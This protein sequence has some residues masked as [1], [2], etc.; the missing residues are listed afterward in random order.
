MTKPQFLPP[1]TYVF[2]FYF[3]VA[4]FISGCAKDQDLFY[5]EVAEDILENNEDISIED[6][7]DNSDV[8][9]EDEK[10]VVIEPVNDAFIQDSK[11][12]NESI[13]RV[14]SDIRTA[15]MMFNLKELQTGISTVDLNITIVEDAGDGLI[16]VYKGS[17]NNWNEE[18]L[19]ESNAPKAVNLLGKSQG[20]YQAQDNVIIPLESG[21]FNEETISLVI[22][23]TN[24]NDI[25]FASKEI[26]DPTMKPNLIINS[27]QSGDLGDTTGSETN[28]GGTPKFDYNTTDDCDFGGDCMYVDASCMDSSYPSI[29]EFVTA[30]VQGGIPSNLE[31]KST[32]TPRDNI[33]TAIDQVYSQGGGTII[34]TPGTYSVTSTINMRSNV[35][36]RGTSEDEVIIESHLR[37]PSGWN[38]KKNTFLFEDTS[39]SGLE[40]LTILFKVDGLEPRD[41]PSLVD[42]GWCSDCYTNDPDGYD[43]LHVRQVYFSGSSTN[44][45]I[46]HSRILKSGNDPIS[47]SGD[48]NTIRNT[49][50][51]QAYNK[52]GGGNGY[53]LITGDH[54]L[55][56]NNTV[57][58]IR[59]I[60]I[61]RGAEYNVIFKNY[62]EVDINF[63]DGDDGNN[64][65][66]QNEINIP[67]WHSWPVIET[68]RATYGHA[69]PGAENIIV[70]NIAD[71]LRLN[72]LNTGELYSK[73]NTIFTLEGFN[74]DGVVET[75][76]SMPTCNTFYP[77]QGN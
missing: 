51:D 49:I 8:T 46:S 65:I 30:G 62:I 23:Q 17:H 2:L 66:E 24:G 50:I 28:T 55:F 31:V 43:D 34:L 29:Y 76:W 57:K 37:A 22:I 1:K 58:R 32:I 36:L 35:V 16:E 70:N 73:S 25:A 10:D 12:Y 11:G 61:E 4:A 48:H 6:P 44:N 56:V 19:T 69:S 9:Q 63:H 71:D 45:W 33:Q 60:S 74:P 52:G 75:N 21:D 5:A 53:V 40:H 15:Y 67:S 7:T 77:V 47:V 59:H 26:E 18:E 20:T 39:Y 13:N 68:G 42:G 72:Q 54:N 64:L 14:E 41:R 3:L 38:N 27:T